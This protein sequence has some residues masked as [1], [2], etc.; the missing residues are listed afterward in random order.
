[1]KIV[2][3]TEDSFIGE[4]FYLFL[5]PKF[6]YFISGDVIFKVKKLFYFYFYFLFIFYFYFL[7]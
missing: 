6:F 3:A 1:M 2:N 7:F 4:N 5:N